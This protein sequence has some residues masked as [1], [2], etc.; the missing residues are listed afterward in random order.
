MQYEKTNRIINYEKYRYNSV[1][2]TNF[3]NIVLYLFKVKLSIGNKRITWIPRDYDPITSLGMTLKDAVDVLLDLTP[4]NYL[5][6][7]SFDHN[8]DGTEIWEFIYIWG[9]NSIPIYIK[10]KFQ[11]SRFK[12]FFIS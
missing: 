6:G 4:K 7:P 2:F 1:S 11:D 9:D 10:L 12:F 5:R 8:G 3:S